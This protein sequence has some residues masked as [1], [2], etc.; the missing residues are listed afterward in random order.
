MES[1]FTR[2]DL[3]DEVRADQWRPAAKHPITSVK[4]PTVTREKQ[5]LNFSI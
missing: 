5:A 4:S 2:S 3:V 1:T